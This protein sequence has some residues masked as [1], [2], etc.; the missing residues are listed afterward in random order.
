MWSTSFTF[1]C[2][3][4]DWAPSQQQ[5]SVS[6]I[7][8]HNLPASSN[9][10][11]FTSLRKLTCS[12][13]LQEDVAIVIHHSGSGPS[14]LHPLILGGSASLCHSI[15]SNQTTVPV[16][17]VLYN[18]FCSSHSSGTPNLYQQNYRGARRTDTKRFVVA[19]QW[20]NKFPSGR[21]AVSLSVFK[22]SPKSYI[23]T[24]H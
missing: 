11:A 12:F 4:H 19:P 24:R 23:F 3:S 16:L 21:K 2:S 5:L 17:R 1:T 7:W 10:T 8:T 20:G 14:G 15:Y 6:G 18:V 22:Q 13:Y 9:T